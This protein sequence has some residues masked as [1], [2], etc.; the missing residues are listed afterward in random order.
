LIFVVSIAGVLL[1]DRKDSFSR[2]M[3]AILVTVS[4]GYLFL[5][6]FTKNRALVNI[7]YGVFSGYAGSFLLTSNRHPLFYFYSVSVM[8]YVFKNLFFLI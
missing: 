7:F 4:L 6:P 2:A 3:I 5:D 1:M 8:V